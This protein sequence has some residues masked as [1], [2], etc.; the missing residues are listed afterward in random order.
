MDL[1]VSVAGMTNS[2]E[3]NSARAH[4]AAM[5]TSEWPDAVEPWG[6]SMPQRAPVQDAPLP[7]GWWI[8]PAAAM[9]CGVWV[10]LCTL[11]F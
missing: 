8:L 7:S 11:I 5:A 6:R 10:L 2:A 9:G 3:A 1:G 4:G